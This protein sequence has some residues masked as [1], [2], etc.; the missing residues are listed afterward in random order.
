MENPAQFWVEINSLCLRD[1]LQVYSSSI[2]H[3]D[4]MGRCRRFW[5]YCPAIRRCSS[6]H[7]KRRQL[8]Y[9]DLEDERNRAREHS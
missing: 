3:T 9:L 1:I 6:V 5:R 7:R 2:G 8:L 4:Q